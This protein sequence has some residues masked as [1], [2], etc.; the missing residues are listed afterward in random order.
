MP[1]IWSRPNRRQSASAA[2]VQVP[3]TNMRTFEPT[4]PVRPESAASLAASTRN[5]PMPSEPTAI[6]RSRA[7][8]PVQEADFPRCG[9]SHRNEVEPYVVFMPHL[10]GVHLELAPLRA[11]GDTADGQFRIVVV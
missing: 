4:V 8:K 3:S 7:V 1:S 5:A 10:E 9:I 2:S 11:A 6:R